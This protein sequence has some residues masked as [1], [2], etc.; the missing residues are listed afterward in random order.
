VADDAVQLARAAVS[1]DPWWLV[2]PVCFAEP[3]APWTAAQR[4]RAVV[5]L[6]PIVRAA[7]ELANRHEWLVVEGVGGLLVP[8][9]ARATV[10]DLATELGLPL[11][12]VARPEL[13]TLN[14]T[15]LSLECAAR[16]RLSVLGIILN[17]SRPPPQDPW[18]RVAIRTNPRC[19]AQLARVP[20]VGPLPF[21]AAGADA[22]GTS[23]E[24][25]AR[26]LARVLTPP[27][28]CATV[29]ASR[30]WT[31]EARACRTR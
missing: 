14:H 26:W 16:R 11:L 31:R 20:V 2:N 22:G 9:T 10:A 6:A 4:S 13:G 3:L 17:H 27:I 12:L 8:L 18:S 21:L 5:R 1:Q 29:S 24:Q 7:R 25:A 30:A 23:W 28:R 19:L 15:L